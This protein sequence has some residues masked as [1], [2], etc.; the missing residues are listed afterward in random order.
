MP[1]D[2]VVCGDCGLPRSFP[3]LY[4]CDQ[5]HGELT[6]DDTRLVDIH[7]AA[8]MLG[9]DAK[10]VS[11]AMSK[12][13][14]FP[15]PRSI[16]KALRTGQVYYFRAIDILAWDYIRRHGK[17]RRKIERFDHVEEGTI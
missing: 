9:R 10:A 15:E 4:E 14:T 1:E 7:E 5:P 13:A 3:D 16:R 11:S 17:F 6:P 8:E 2:E 12:D